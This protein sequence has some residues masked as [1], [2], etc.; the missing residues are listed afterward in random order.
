MGKLPTGAFGGMTGKVGKLVSYQLRGQN[1][2]RRIGENK[3]P[4]TIPQLAVR[5]RVSL[6]SGFLSQMKGVINLGYLF[7]AEGNVKHQQNLAIAYN[8]KNAMLGEYPDIYIDYTEV[9]TSSGKLPPASSPTALKI[10]NQIE[11]KWQYDNELDYAVRND[12]AMIVLFFQEKNETIYFL[13]GSTRSEG[14]QLIRIPLD[15]IDQLCNIYL[16]FF[17]EDRLSVSDSKHIYVW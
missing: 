11:I 14:T 6:M 10:D 12:R 7:E 13:S 4:A 9:M 1:V 8:V 15:L 2:V 17:A 5:Q 3:K 16:S